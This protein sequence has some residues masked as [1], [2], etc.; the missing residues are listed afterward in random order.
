MIRMK[1]TTMSKTLTEMTKQALDYNNRFKEQFGANLGIE[2]LETYPG[3]APRFL[4]SYEADETHLNI[5]KGVHGGTIGFIFD[6]VMGAAGDAATD[7]DT[8][9][10]D[11][12]IAYV[13]PMMDR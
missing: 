1:G 6:T 3:E 10:V 7:K 2:L 4:F 12:S 11:L 5:F 9:T 8:S 13:R